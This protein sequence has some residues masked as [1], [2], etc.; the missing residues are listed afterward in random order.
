MPPTVRQRAAQ[1]DGELDALGS[2]REL[3]ASAE[4][5]RSNPLF[6]RLLAAQRQAC[7]DGFEKLATGNHVAKSDDYEQMGWKLR[8]VMDLHNELTVAINRGK[9]ASRRTEELQQ[10]RGRIAGVPV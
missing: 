9:T 10:Q 4:A 8:A 7:F 3:A 1:I 6:S 5:L 2:D